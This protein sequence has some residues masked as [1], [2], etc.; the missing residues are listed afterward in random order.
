[1]ARSNALWPRQQKGEPP[2]KERLKSSRHDR[3]SKLES[4]SRVRFHCAAEG[5]DKWHEWSVR[6]WVKASFLPSHGVEVLFNEFGSFFGC[7]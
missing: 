6:G 7:T 5:E 4:V 1:M 3:F 2:D